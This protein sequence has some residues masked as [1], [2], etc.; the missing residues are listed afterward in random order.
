LR[1]L[2]DA[3]EVAVGHAEA[4]EAD[5]DDVAVGVL[6][7]DRHASRDHARDAR[8]GEQLGQRRE[9]RR[10]LDAVEVGLR[11]RHAGGVDR[12]CIQ[13]GVVR[14][15]DAPR[16]RAGAGFEATRSATSFSTSEVDFSPRHVE[17]AVAWPNSGVSGLASSHFLLA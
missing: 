6:G 17:R 12:R 7:I 9:V 16:L 13:I 2:S 10:V 5:R 8:L 14:I 15:D 1:S 11:R 4:V 3:V